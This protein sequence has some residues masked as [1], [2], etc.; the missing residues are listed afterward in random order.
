M[1]ITLLISILF[2]VSCKRDKFDVDISQINTPIVLHEFDNDIFNCNK[3][4]I[5]DEIYN[6]S[7]KYGKFWDLYT[8]Q[9]LKMGGTN[10]KD[11][12]D[13][14]T[15][16]ISDPVILESYEKSREIFPDKN[17]LK[18]KLEKAFRYYKFYYPDKSIPDLYTFIGGFN[19]SIIT[20]ENIIGIGLDKY[21]GGNCKFYDQLQIPSFAKTKLDSK[22]II[23]DCMQ[24]W[25]YM[26]M[27]LKDSLGYLIN[28]ML[29][30]GKILY[31][32]N[33]MN[34][35]YTEDF[36]MKYSPVELEWCE[37]NEK[38]M[39]KYMV[40]KKLLFSTDYK[41][42]IRFI[43]DGPFTPAFSQESPARAGLWIGFRI[44]KKYMDKNSD[45]TLQNLMD[46]NDYQKILSM[47]KYNP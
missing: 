22:Y 21:Y 41:N 10:D 30:E 40:E 34:P 45:V 25:A 29:Y 13:L 20:D 4:S 11:F 31:F 33:A 26:E 44:I 6:L 16:F 46:D 32:I 28:S 35:G 42:L 18:S 37:Q 3:D 9:I 36:Y 2:I 38:T 17:I 23:N 15:A 24:A 43:D 47:S 39:W 7:N 12:A 14:F 5:W 27:P 8:Y 19:H 1:L